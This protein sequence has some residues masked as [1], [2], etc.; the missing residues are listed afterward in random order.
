[1]R[2]AYAVGR[3]IYLRAPTLADAQGSWFEWFSD[4]EV[5]QFLGDRYWPNTVE[6]QEAF[7]NSINNSESRMVLSVIDKETDEH[8]G[9]C[10]LSGINWVHRYADFALVIGDKRHRN[11]AV[12]IECTA[13]MLRIAFM[14]LNLRIVRGGYTTNNP[15]TEQ[16][17]RLFRFEIV[18]RFKALVHHNGQYFDAV[19]A[20]LDRDD[21]MMRNL[22]TD[23]I[24]DSA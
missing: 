10:N 22:K 8:I 19:L 16:L 13:M 21:W 2:N 17:L 20:Q 1:M 3:K 12:A 6:R 14:R 24:K 15:Y 11:G 9:V 23:G 4:E 5:T 7:F 18:G